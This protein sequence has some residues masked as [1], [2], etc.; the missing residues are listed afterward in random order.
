MWFDKGVSTVLREEER[1]HH[2]LGTNFVDWSISY[3]QSIS[4][5]QLSAGKM[6]HLVHRWGQR[7]L[8]SVPLLNSDVLI[9]HALVH[10]LKS[11]SCVLIMFQQELSAQ[12][13]NPFNSSG[14]GAS[15]ASAPMKWEGG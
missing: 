1:S 6:Q 4:E 8:W 10:C 12:L 7:P 11:A 13:E 9:T 5:R 2:R 14:G 15:V 3:H